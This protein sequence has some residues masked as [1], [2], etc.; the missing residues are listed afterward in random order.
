MERRDFGLNWNAELPKGGVMVENDV[1]LSVHL[2]LA[3]EE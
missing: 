2:E 1:T 3:K